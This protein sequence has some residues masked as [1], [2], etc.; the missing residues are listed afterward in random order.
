MAARQFQGKTGKTQGSWKAGKVTHGFKDLDV[1]GYIVRY[2]YIIIQN[3]S[4]KTN[5]TLININF[6]KH[7]I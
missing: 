2:K 1:L 3:K 6:Q 4:Y 5:L 7:S